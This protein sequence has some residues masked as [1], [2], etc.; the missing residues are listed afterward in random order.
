MRAINPLVNRLPLKALYV[1]WAYDAWQQ[2][3]VDPRPLHN[4]PAA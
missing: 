2:V 3:G 1:P 4:K